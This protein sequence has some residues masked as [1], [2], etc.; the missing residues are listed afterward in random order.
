MDNDLENPCGLFAIY[1]KLEGKHDLDIITKAAIKEGCYTNSGMSALSI[2]KY[3][4]SDV[5]IANRYDKESYT[6]YVK[7][8]YKLLSES[9]R[10][11][12]ELR[13]Y[14]LDEYAKLDDNRLMGIWNCLGI[15][16]MTV[17]SIGALPENGLGFSCEFIDNIDKT[18]SGY[19]Y[20]ESISDYYAVR[21][22]SDDCEHEW[23]TNYPF[24]L[25]VLPGF[26]VGDEHKYYY[27]TITTMRVIIR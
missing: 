17:K 23:V 16:F 7:R 22:V 15:H 24:M 8:I 19:F 2:A 1:N 18:V 10:P 6:E 25:V 11:I 21:D 27:R 3:V 14:S 9:H 4:D 13:K 12:V 26:T 20:F 5:I